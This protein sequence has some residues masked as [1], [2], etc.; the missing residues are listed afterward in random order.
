LYKHQDCAGILLAME[1]QAQLFKNNDS[2]SAYLGWGC[3][4]CH[5]LTQPITVLVDI[6]ERL[7]LVIITGILDT[8][9][10]CIALSR[11]EVLSEGKSIIVDVGILVT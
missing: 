1:K 7:F 11:V 6:F 3:L 4:D 8:N 9:M 10:F 2:S 5:M